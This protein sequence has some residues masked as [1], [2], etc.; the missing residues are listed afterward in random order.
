MENKNK[1]KE[2]QPFLLWLDKG[3]RLKLR[4]EL[5]KRNETMTAFLGKVIKREI[6][7]GTTNDANTK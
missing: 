6:G 2:R 7:E 1:L 5:L 4:I 3:D